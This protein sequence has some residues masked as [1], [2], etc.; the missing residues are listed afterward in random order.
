M[1]TIKRTSAIKEITD[2]ELLAIPTY[3]AVPKAGVKCFSEILRA[4]GYY[5][6]NRSKT[7]YQF[8]KP[9]TAWDESGGKAH[10]RN[11]PNK[12]MPF[13]AVFN[14]MTTHESQVWKRKEEVIFDPVSI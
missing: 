13:F 8:H 4:N 9:I 10:W 5:C 12:D 2:P 11:R 3:E 7:D 1:R 6:T 14:I